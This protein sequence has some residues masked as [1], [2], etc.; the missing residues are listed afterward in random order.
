MEANDASL[1]DQTSQIMVYLD[2]FWKHYTYVLY[3][4]QR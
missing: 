4:K 3:F 2:R 1:N